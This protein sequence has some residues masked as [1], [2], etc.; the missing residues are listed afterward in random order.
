M[1]TAVLL[2]RLFGTLA[3]VSERVPATEAWRQAPMLRQVSHRPWPLPG[4]PWLM[5]QTWQDVLFAHWPVTSD[6]VASLLPSALEPDT[7]AG[8]AWMSVV[9][10]GISNV[11]LR[12]WPA[13]P[14]LREFPEVNLRTYVRYQGQP[15]VWFV[16]LDCPNW[17]VTRLA[18][19]WYLLP[20]RFRR[21]ATFSASYRFSGEPCTAE[22]GSLEHW[23]V[24]RYAY[25]ARDRAGSLYRCDI[26]HEPW[27]LHDADV[28]ITHNELLPDAGAPVIAE[29]VKR[30]E[31]VVWP[32]SP[33]RRQSASAPQRA[34]SAQPALP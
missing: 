25:F 27:L 33:L 7:Y 11:H 12:G 8:R 3:S 21:G 9:A 17:L 22:P 20:Y 26:H 10:F 34:P 4:G 1:N 24:E 15:G 29:Y 30:I 23:L 19:P 28:H 31:A 16:S 2:A 13:M 18:R 5:A 14:L 32:I 6:V